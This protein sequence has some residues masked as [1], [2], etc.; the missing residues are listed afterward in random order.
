M[1]RVRQRT[2]PRPERPPRRLTREARREQL[3]AIAMPVIAAQGLAEFSLDEIAA[4]ADVTRNLLYHYFPR[5]RADLVL[6]AVE[7]AGH[8]LTDDWVTDEAVPVAERVAQNNARIVAQALQPTDAWQL[9]RLVRGTNVPELREVF[10]R[11]VEL[12]VTN[13]SLNHLGTP[14]PPPLAR[15]AFVAYLAFVEALLDEVRTGDFP[16]EEIVE[17]LNETLA[18]ALGAAQASP[19]P[20]R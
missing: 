14:D 19:A 13:M 18:G 2:A 16:P 8:D 3:V 4:R 17:L 6:A 10:D 20:P 15:L 9:H 5:G 11:F 1:A 12:V 7:R